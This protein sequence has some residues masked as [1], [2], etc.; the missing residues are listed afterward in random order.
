[1]T[2]DTLPAKLM[3]ISHQALP[4]SL[5]GTSAGICQMNGPEMN[6]TQM[7]MHNRSENGYSAWDAL[8]NTT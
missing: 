4:A 6:R 7:G 8:Y 2:G 1:M 5:L 3:Y